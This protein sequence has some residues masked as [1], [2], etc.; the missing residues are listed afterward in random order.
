MSNKKNSNLDFSKYLKY[1]NKYLDLK[2]NQKGGV[3]FKNISDPDPREIE[4]VLCMENLDEPVEGKHVVFF[5][6]GHGFCNC[7]LRQNNQLRNCPTCSEPIK[8]CFF[9]TPEKYKI[10]IWLVKNNLSVVDFIQKNDKSYLIPQFITNYEDTT[11]DRPEQINIKTTINLPNK[12]KHSVILRYDDN[13]V[14]FIANFYN[15]EP[16]YIV[17]TI[18][19]TDNVIHYGL[20]PPE[21]IDIEDKTPFLNLTLIEL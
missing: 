5:E 21:V 6:C 18:E 4:C 10:L 2:L 15:I 13:I 7:F 11:I 16:D 1:K 8:I 20:T 17:L 9:I 14:K 19:G 12:K 3:L